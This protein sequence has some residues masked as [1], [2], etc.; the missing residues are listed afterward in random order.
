MEQSE[1]PGVIG[2][3]EILRPTV[4]AILAHLCGGE[5]RCR[6]F[7]F[8]VEWCESRGDCAYAVVCP[9]CS[10]QFLVSDEDLEELRRWTDAEGNALV[11]GV[12]WE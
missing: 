5:E 12:R 1:L 2:D 4:R 10:L 7:G 6:Q 11:C 8:V 9:G 3:D